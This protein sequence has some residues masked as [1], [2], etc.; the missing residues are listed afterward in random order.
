WAQS[1]FR[2]EV[3]GGLARLDSS[4]T[5]HTPGGSNPGTPGATPST[6]STGFSSAQA[7]SR[8]S[9]LSRLDNRKGG[10]R[11]P[12]EVK[13]EIGTGGGG[14]VQVSASVVGSADADDKDG[15][16]GKRQRRQRTHFTSQQLQELE[17]TFARNR[18]P[19]MT[20]REEI[21][22]WTSL[23][24]ARVRV[25]FKNRR[26]KWRKRERNA[27]NAAA[28]AAENFK[29]GFGTASLNSFI[30][31]PFGD[32]ES[33]YNY[34]SY[35]NWASKVP[36]PLNSKS[37]S[38]PVN[39]LSSVVQSAA[40]AAHHHHP[41]SSP[42]NCF[43]SAGSLGGGHVGGMSVSVAQAPTSM[44]PGM[45]SGLGVAGSPVAA[46]SAGCYVAPAAP[47]HPAYGPPVYSHHRA[48]GPASDPMSTSIASLRLK[49]QQ[50]KQ[51]GGS[52]SSGGIG[53][54]TTASAGGSYSGF[55]S[56][57]G[58]GG[59]TGTGSISPVSSRASSGGGG[60]S[61]CQYA[62]AASGTNPHSPGAERSQQV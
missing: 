51:H 37:F 54:S 26:A 60:L 20:T 36:S 3:N 2:D 16:K 58:A 19:D 40:A 24:E 61:A 45:S 59:S 62:L 32:P 25:W 53:G 9:N 35:N 12:T 49:A 1:D 57:L 31:Q 18:Y 13:H 8:N 17:A 11:T 42:V 23:S 28:A 33:L 10:G 21:A 15:K 34:S 52:G 4:T 50:A 30:G 41:H 14:G 56:A 55:Q 29:S 46:S 48:T 5:A 43:N 6:P 27:I 47:H 7:R 44:I 38:W 39:P 22:M